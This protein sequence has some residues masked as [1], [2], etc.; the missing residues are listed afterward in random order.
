LELKRAAGL[1]MNVKELEANK[2]LT[3]WTVLDLNADKM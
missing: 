2:A 3:D 1:G